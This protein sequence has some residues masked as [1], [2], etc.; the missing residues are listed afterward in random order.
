MDVRGA[1]ARGA[2]AKHTYRARSLASSRARA[3]ARRASSS[4]RRRRS[5][6]VGWFA[7]LLPTRYVNERLVGTQYQAWHFVAVVRNASAA[8]PAMRALSWWGADEHAWAPKV[9]RTPPWRSAAPT[10]LG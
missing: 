2:T 9:R 8:P 6:Q 3:R 10:R 4:A 1:S 7:A 5:Q